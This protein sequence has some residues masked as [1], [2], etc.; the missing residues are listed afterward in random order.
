MNPEKNINDNIQSWRSPPVCVIPACG[1][2]W[3]LLMNATPSAFPLKRRKKCVRFGENA[4]NHDGMNPACNIVDNLLAKCFK[5]TYSKDPRKRE[6]AIPCTEDG[7][8]KGMRGINP[9]VRLCILVMREFASL[10]ERVEALANGVE[11]TVFP[12]G[13]DIS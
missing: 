4:K 12:Q 5:Y 6:L 9:D 8:R 7:V 11:I 2:P 10:I 1:N 3:T 13:G